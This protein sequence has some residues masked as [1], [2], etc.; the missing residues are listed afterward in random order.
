MLAERWPEE[1]EFCP[2]T[3]I[4]ELHPVQPDGGLQEGVL[5][6]VT[7]LGGPQDGVLGEIGAKPGDVTELGGPQ[8]GVSG[9][10]GA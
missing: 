7:E 6:V 10:M 9:E 1:P 5:G 3:I 8:D 2:G 4:T